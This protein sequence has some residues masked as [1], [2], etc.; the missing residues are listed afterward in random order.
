MPYIGRRLRHVCHGLSDSVKSFNTYDS[1]HSYSSNRTTVQ[2][3]SPLYPN[4]ATKKKTLQWNIR[5]MTNNHRVLMDDVQARKIPLQVVHYCAKC[6]GSVE[7]PEDLETKNR[8][9][10]LRLAEV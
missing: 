4:A 6:E 5:G 1:L 3:F 2:S 8:F 7:V 9:R 10:N